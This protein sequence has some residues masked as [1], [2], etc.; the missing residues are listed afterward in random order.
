MGGGQKDCPSCPP[1]LYPKPKFWYGG[2]RNQNVGQRWCPTIG[3]LG[4]SARWEKVVSNGRS[5]WKFRG[6]FFY[7]QIL[8]LNYFLILLNLSSQPRNWNLTGDIYPP[9]PPPPAATLLV[10]NKVWV[11]GA[12]EYFQAFPVVLEKI[13]FTVSIVSCVCSQIICIFLTSPK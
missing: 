5:P 3:A 12:Y 13:C 8:I 1:P 7:A 11:L 9:P 6:A 10:L 2:A 4:S